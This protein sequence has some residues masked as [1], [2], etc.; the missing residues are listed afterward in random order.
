MNKTQR[1][2]LPPP[3]QINKF[4]KRQENEAQN[5]ELPS[6]DTKFRSLGLQHLPLSALLGDSQN[7]CSPPQ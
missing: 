4:K 2:T 3:P 1:S 6:W 5:N 7:Y